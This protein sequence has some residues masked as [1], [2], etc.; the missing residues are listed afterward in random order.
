MPARLA[1][2]SPVPP[3]GWA[4]LPGPGRVTAGPR[5]GQREGSRDRL[6][7]QVPFYGKGQR[8]VSAD[9]GRWAALGLVGL[10]SGACAG[11]GAASKG[12]QGAKDQGELAVIHRAP[13]AGETVHPL[14]V[15]A[16][17]NPDVWSFTVKAK[18]ASGEVSDRLTRKE[19]DLNRDGR[20]DVA[21][22]YDADGR[23][24]LEAMDLDFDGR[25]DQVNHYDAKGQ[26]T[27][28][29]RDLDS[30]GKVDL[31]LYYERGALVRK[32]RDTNGDG[33]VE[34]WEEWLDGHVD[35][36]GE[37]LDGD[38]QVDRWT[39]SPAAAADEG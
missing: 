30:N 21:R 22:D 34:V 14:D 25:V 13:A 8:Q 35:R 38:G 3:G 24:I 10:L 11:S 9:I 28:K 33:R 20:V 6:K 39:H 15:N 7:G 12:M 36:I 4:P 17:G 2:A 31:W 5:P 16:D 29:E 27:R 37:D 1:F 23:L 32:E 26:I 19:L 18:H